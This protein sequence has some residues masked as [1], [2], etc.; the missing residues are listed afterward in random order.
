MERKKV[1][2]MGA[3]GRDFHNFN[4]FYKNKKE[5]EVVAFTANQIPGIANK[6]YPPTL[7]GKYYPKGISI[8]PEKKLVDL[9]KKLSVDE[10][11]FSYSDV[12]HEYV[13]NR[14]SIVLSTGANFVL[15]GGKATEITSV[16]FI[17]SIC[18]TRT[19]CGKSQTARYVVKILKELG[20]KVVVVRHPMPYGNLKTQGLQ[21]FE[22]FADLEKHHCTIEEREEYEPHLEAKTVVYAGIDYQSILRAAEK[23]AEVIVWDGGNNDLPFYRSNLR[24]VVIDP[25]RNGDELTYH[26]GETN[27]LLADVIII[28]KENVASKKMIAKTKENIGL[29]NP[30]AIVIDAVSI[31][32]TENPNLIKNKKVLILEDGPTL[33]H[34]GLKIGA[35]YLMAKK[36]KASQI[37]SPF[38]Y[39]IGTIKK[40]YKNYPHVKEVLPAMGYDQTQIRELEQ[41]I[42]QVPA[43]TVVIGTPIDLSKIIKINQPSARVRYELEE[44][45]RP[46]LKKIIIRS[47]K[48]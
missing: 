2:I 29:R 26:P 27:L 22:T 36:W 15:L 39:A 11:V 18:A 41:T 4:V 45:S 20:K 33:T 48:K 10:V 12:S 3:A 38:P 32:K 25:L 28:N 5:C 14:A 34:G 37:I 21:R 44:R 24:I 9:I 7:T 19:G 8:Y 43:E 23:E 6:I 16:K 17:I 31:I 46:K 47:L 13:M 30:K 1:I 40:T 35:G 42:K